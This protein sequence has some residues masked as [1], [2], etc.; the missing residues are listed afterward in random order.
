MAP[1]A[2]RI[3][4]FRVQG[5]PKRHLPPDWHEL[6]MLSKLSKSLDGNH[7]GSSAAGVCMRSSSQG[8][9]TQDSL[10]LQVLAPVQ[11]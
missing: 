10:A 3:A 5:G 9:P 6:K 11:T 4:F 1:S 8:A 7:F 2:S